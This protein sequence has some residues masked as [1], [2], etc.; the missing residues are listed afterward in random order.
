METEPSTEQDEE[1]CNNIMSDYY[2]KLMGIG[3]TSGGDFDRSQIKASLKN[4]L[5]EIN[6]ELPKMPEVT[7]VLENM[8]QDL[9]ESQYISIKNSYKSE[10]LT[11]DLLES[12]YMSM[13][14]SY[15]SD[16]NETF[17]PEDSQISEIN[18]IETLNKYNLIEKKLS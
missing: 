4:Q 7:P 15:K 12:Q 11:K 5:K 1:K 16:Y 6:R 18:M 9:D 10:N 8:K 13:E 17:M 14:N 2:L 3:S